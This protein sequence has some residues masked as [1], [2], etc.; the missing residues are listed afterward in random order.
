V[1]ASG[2][3]SR[4]EMFT[5]IYL[6]AVA[7]ALPTLVGENVGAGHMDRVRSSVSIVQGMRRET[8]R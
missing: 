2:V 6:R 1:A 8:V 5:A 3:G 4:I 7:G